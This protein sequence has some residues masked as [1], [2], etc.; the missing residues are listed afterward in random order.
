MTVDSQAV[1][2]KVGNAKSETEFYIWLD[3]IITEFR[4]RGFAQ[5]L[6]EYQ[7]NWAKNA[8]FKLITVKTSQDFPRMLK[9]LLT[10]NYKCQV[11]KDALVNQNKFLLTK[12]I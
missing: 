2:Y 6:L 11:E 8:N 3:A 4:G 10:N 1:G 7:E 9:L 12:E 5:A